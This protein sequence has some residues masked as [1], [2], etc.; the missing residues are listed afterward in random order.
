MRGKNDFFPDHADLQTYYDFAME[1]GAPPNHQMCRYRGVRA[2]PRGKRHICLG[3][4][5]RYGP[6]AV[7]KPAGGR[8]SRR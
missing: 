4:D 7:A 6:T 8:K 5:G 3:A 2:L 1:L